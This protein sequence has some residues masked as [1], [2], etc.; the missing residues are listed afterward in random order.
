MQL[1]SVVVGGVIGILGTLVVTRSSQTYEQAEKVRE[2]RRNKL[3]HMVSKAL[4]LQDW[5]FRERDYLL[6]DLPHPEGTCPINE[7]Q[8]IAFLYASDITDITDRLKADTLDFRNWVLKAREEVES[9]GFISEKHGE[10]VKDIG[11]MMN[12]NVNDLVMYTCEMI[13]DIDNR[14]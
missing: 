1:A 7:I 8:T 5:L 12:F 13:E 4:E 11:K 3:E 10:K 2:I 6:E 9:T 14:C